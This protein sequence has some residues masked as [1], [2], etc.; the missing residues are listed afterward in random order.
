MFRCC[1]LQ[2]HLLQQ[3]QQQQQQQRQRAMQQ[4]AAVQFGGAGQ[5]QPQYPGT[6][7]DMSQVQSQPQFIRGNAA[8]PP[9]YS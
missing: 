4:A 7:A 6:S 5:H 9:P 2:Q 8:P 3:Q 1:V